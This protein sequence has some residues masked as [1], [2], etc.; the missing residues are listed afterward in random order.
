VSCYGTLSKEEWEA[1]QD[2]IDAAQREAWIANGASDLL[3]ALER[4]QRELRLQWPQQWERISA[5]PQVQSYFAQF[6]KN[7]YRAV[8][9]A[10]WWSGLVGRCSSLIDRLAHRLHIPYKREPEQVD[11]LNLR[12][13]LP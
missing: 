12:Q 7:Y 3:P 6:D 2:I 9:I 10:A 8:R 11:R 4:Q 13:P 1:E 5:L